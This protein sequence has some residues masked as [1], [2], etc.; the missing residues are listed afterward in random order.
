MDIFYRFKQALKEAARAARV[1][2]ESGLADLAQ[3]I[4]YAADWESLDAQLVV[5]RARS[6]KRQQ[7]VLER[8]EPLAKRVEA[9]LEAARNAKIK[10][11]RQNLLRQAEG[12]MRELESEDEAAKIHSANGRMLT[13]L[14][15][16]VRRARAMGER[17][18]D[19]EVI[20]AIAA[21]L[22]EAVVAQEGASDAAAELESAGAFDTG[23]EVSV[24][25]VENRLSAVY[26][27]D[28][29]NEQERSPVKG[30]EVVSDLENRLY[31]ET[32]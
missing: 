2:P 7:E 21:H 5:L 8:L 12:F 31:A 18:V 14:V 27:D 4:D 15:K 24:A 32:A 19:A 25:E 29:P 20:E 16:Q 22:E 17:G 9:L 10:V 30:S 28:G 11:V 3:M 13:E 1:R 23:E 6:R 26:T